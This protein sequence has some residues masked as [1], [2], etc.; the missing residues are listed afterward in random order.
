LKLVIIQQNTMDELTDSGVQLN[1]QRCKWKHILIE[2][3]LMF[4]CLGIFEFIFF[5][6][7]ILHYSPITDAE[8]KYT[9][10]KQLLEPFLGKYDTN[11]NTKT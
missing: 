1:V 2:N 6:N 5:I 8:I 3:V 10:A 4:V 11:T 9:I 7:I